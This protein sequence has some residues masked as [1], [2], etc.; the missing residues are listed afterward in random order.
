[1]GR[2]FSAIE[3]K[4]FAQTV[5]VKHSLLILPVDLSSLAEKK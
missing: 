5:L 3:A 1:M 2:S 4:N